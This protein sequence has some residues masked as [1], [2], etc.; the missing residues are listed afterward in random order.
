MAV[1]EG[2]EVG[3]RGLQDENDVAQAIGA[4]Q[5][6]VAEY[7]VVAIYG[8]FPAALQ[9]ALAHR[10]ESYAVRIADSA[11]G[12]YDPADAG[13]PCFAAWNIMRAADGGRPTFEHRRFCY[14]GRLPLPAGRTEK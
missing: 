4:I 8:V 3:G 14:V 13:V 11:T 6:L 5:A 2:M 1:A 10:M 12:E 7:G 9:E